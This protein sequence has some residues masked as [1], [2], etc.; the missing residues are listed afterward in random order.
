[1]RISDWSSD[2]CSSDL[3]LKGPQTTYFGN[4]AISGALNIITNIPD[5][6]SGGRARAI[7]GSYGAFAAEAAVNIPL[8]DRLAARIAGLANGQKGWVRN[9]VDGAKGPCERNSVG[10][11]RSAEQTSELQSPMRTS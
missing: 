2:V 10:R 4:N 7:Y 9:V 1:M 6:E 5:F 3:V 11:I 8:S